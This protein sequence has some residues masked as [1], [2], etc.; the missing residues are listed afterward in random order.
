MMKKI[1]KNTKASKQMRPDKNNDG[2][3][4]SRRKRVK[5]RIDDQDA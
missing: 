4:T 1:N 2:T 3:G 5:R